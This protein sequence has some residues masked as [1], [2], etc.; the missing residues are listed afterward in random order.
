MQY[1]YWEHLK[2]I[3]S[4]YTG[5]GEFYT[6]LWSK[7]GGWS[8]RF[9]PPSKAI[10]AIRKTDRPRAKR[11]NLML[12]C[13]TA[14]FKHPVGKT[15]SACADNVT[16]IYEI[17]LD[18]DNEE[19]KT[20]S[21]DINNDWDMEL[22]LND[23]RKRQWDK[24]RQIL[25]SSGLLPYA[26]VISSGSGLHVHFFFKEI[27]D[28]NVPLKGIAGDLDILEIREYIINE[29]IPLL[30]AD[31]GPSRIAAKGKWVNDTP[32]TKV[33]FPVSVEVL[34]DAREFLSFRDFWDKVRMIRERLTEKGSTHVGLMGEYIGP[35]EWQNSDGS[36]MVI[37]RDYSMW[38]KEETGKKDGNDDPI[39]KYRKVK[40]GYAVLP[41][42]MV[43]PRRDDDGEPV[44]EVLFICEAV[45]ARESKLVEFPQSAFETPEKFQKSFI[46]SLINFT[47]ER[48]RGQFFSYFLDHSERIDAVD[49]GKHSDMMVHYDFI[50]KYNQIWKAHNRIVEIITPDGKEKYYIHGADNRRENEKDPRY[51]REH[52]NPDGAIDGMLDK[53]GKIINNKSKNQ[54]GLAWATA[55]MVRDTIIDKYKE[56]PNLNLYGEA[57]TGK[58][59]FMDAVCRIFNVR[60]QTA[61]PTIYN[62]YRKQ[63]EMKNMIIALDDFADIDYYRDFLKD[64]VRSSIRPRRTE[65]GGVSFPEIR[66]SLI[67]TTNHAITDNA[68]S[69]RTLKLFYSKNDMIEDLQAYSE[70]D[71]YVD[72]NQLSIMIDIQNR[73]NRIDWKQVSEMVDTLTRYGSKRIRDIRLAKMYAI[74]IS[75]GVETGI[76]TDA[77]GV[78]DSVYEVES[79]MVNEKDEFLE[80]IVD[81]AVQEQSDHDGDPPIRI[82]TE[83][84]FKATDFTKHLI[85]INYDN[86]VTHKTVSREVAPY[87]AFI[88]KHRTTVR[89]QGHGAFYT[90]DFSHPEF[91]DYFR[92]IEG[93]FAVVRREDAYSPG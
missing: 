7:G 48:N 63:K 66:N 17:L 6:G 1:R 50:Y 69:N 20:G 5:E 31:P 57:G 76:I 84:T 30:D 49:I 53:L 51:S 56:M 14:L 19:F 45:C 33:N 85:K 70:F 72:D 44:G 10:D 3:F 90:V 60:E 9:R 81:F 22:L 4:T 42:Y 2:N 79:Y 93:K 29:L 38:I 11:E 89:G 18:I 25:D 58:T 43:I 34:H 36:C 59:T 55:A 73:V 61:H 28:I 16:D 32:Y 35:R 77:A 71:L 26:T 91:R 12:S 47:V 82:P 13:G 78:M 62:I 40:T 46:K 86:F 54:L 67:M 68:V 37:N 80:T 75:I 8:E 27:V 92:A 23:T 64:S 88:K 21:K 52:P 39:F 74:I 41:K 65:D 24:I 87:R 83:Y 15:Q